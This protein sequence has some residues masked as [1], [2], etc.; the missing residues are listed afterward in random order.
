M[1]IQLMFVVLAAVWAPALASAQ[2][3]AGRD[4]LR[5]HSQEFRREVITVVPGVHVAVGFDLGNAILI[6]GADG[7]IIVDTL[8]SVAAA[9]AVKPE[10]DRIST[11]PLKAIIYTHHHIDHVGGA[12][13][14]AEGQSPEIYAHRSLLPENRAPNVGRGGRDGGNQFGSALPEALKINDGIG[15]RLVPG[16]GAGAP[17]VRPTKLFDGDRTSIEVAGVRM[18]LVLAPGE[19]DD[20]IYVWLPEKKVLLPGDNFYRAFPNLYAIRGVPMRRVDLWVDSLTRMISQDAEHLVPSHTR[21]LSG[22]ALVRDALTAY[23]DGVKSVLD[24]TVAGMREG[25][26][27]DELVERVKLPAELASN[28]YLPGVLRH[29]RLVGPRH[30]QLSPGLVRR[31]RN[32]PVSAVDEPA[33]GQGP[34]TGRR[35]SHRAGQGARG[36][37]QGGVPVGGGAGRLRVGGAAPARR[38]TPVERPRPDGTG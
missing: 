14:F 7:L 9:R 10:F 32:E 16:A 36:A 33:C 5:A 29:R 31:E 3:F 11:K 26:R 17:F 20:Q 21:P 24:Q 27:P 18:D 23:R 4:K 6:E 8:A 28:P 22:A 30:L 12:S 19:T 38:R 25:L 35:R 2:E 34:R 13:V 37:R 1:R 15:P